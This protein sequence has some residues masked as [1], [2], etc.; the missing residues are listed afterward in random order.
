[1]KA[2]TD[3][4]KQAL[5][6]KEDNSKVLPEVFAADGQPSIT[7]IASGEIGQADNFG[8]LTVSYKGTSVL[9]KFAR[10]VAKDLQAYNLQLMKSVREIK[11]TGSDPIPAGYKV[12]R[13]V[14]PN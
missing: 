14:A 2:T 7:D 5:Q 8:R 3:F 10:G 9:A 13:L 6:V 1:M 12:W 4:A 11:I